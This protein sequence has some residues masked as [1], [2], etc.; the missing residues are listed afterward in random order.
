MSSF[1]K[2]AIER[3]VRTIVQA[4]AAAVLALWIQAGSFSE[5]DW[6]AVW[7]V[8]L[9]AAGFTLLTALA[10]KSAG[11]PDDASFTGGDK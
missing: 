9:F 8:A 1:S 10:G 3:I 6:T 5:L 7:Q 2:D 11:S 4:S